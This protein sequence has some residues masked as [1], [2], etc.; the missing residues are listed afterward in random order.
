MR[1]GGGRRRWRNEDLNSP[2]RQCLKK[3]IHSKTRQRRIPTEAVNTQQK[4]PFHPAVNDSERALMGGAGKR[5]EKDSKSAIAD[6]E[7]KQAFHH[8]TLRRL[9]PK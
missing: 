6:G 2:S 8:I 1:K 9:R 5:K 7:K 3:G 4:L